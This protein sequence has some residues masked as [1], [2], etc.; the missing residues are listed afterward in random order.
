MIM[1]QTETKK[2]RLDDDVNSFRVKVS[3]KYHGYSRRYFLVN[4]KTISS[5][6]PQ[7]GRLGRSFG[8]S[9]QITLEMIL[10]VL[11]SQAAFAQAILPIAHSRQESFFQHARTA[12]NLQSFSPGWLS[13]RNL[14]ERWSN[15][16]GKSTRVGGGVRGRMRRAREY[17]W[18]KGVLDTL[19]SGGF[20]CTHVECVKE[21][22]FLWAFIRL[23]VPQMVLLPCR[24]D[25][26]IEDPCYCP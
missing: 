26:W 13:L 4:S 3:S 22:N 1:R 20:P 6:V 14:G 18:E 25:H 16:D 17:L 11:N 23:R 15:S 10:N 12:T 21:K 2:F 8:H 9:S 19:L 24:L 5:Q 7:C